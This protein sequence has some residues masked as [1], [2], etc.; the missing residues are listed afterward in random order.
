MSCQFEIWIDRDSERL[1][2]RVGIYNGL[3]AMTILSFIVA[4]SRS[5]GTPDRT[6]RLET[7]QM[8]ERK[9]RPG[10]LTLPE[11]PRSA[12]PMNFDN[13]DIPLRYLKNAQW[14]NARGNKD[15]PSPLPLT[16]NPA[17]RAPREESESSAD[18]DYFPSVSPFPLALSPLLPK[19]PYSAGKG[20]SDQDEALGPLAGAAG[21][22]F[23][24]GESSRS[25]AT[26]RPRRYS[27][28]GQNARLGL[29]AKSSTGGPRWCKK[30][31]GW[32]PDRCH[33][34]RY[35]DKCVLKSRFIPVVADAVDYQW[36]IIVCG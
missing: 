5:P 23:P 32:K 13:D 29:M 20:S 33:H 1:T 31:D 6:H 14:V 18:S 7:P 8:R 9:D 35:C 2:H 34:C 36:T 10:A 30:C 21:F 24:L 3:F 26:Q 11:P 4:S 25:S 16:T 27:T 19:S 17:S 12:P 28:P 15:R 22:D